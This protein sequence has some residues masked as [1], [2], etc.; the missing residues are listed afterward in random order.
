MT[1]AVQVAYVA[2]VHTPAMPGLWLTSVPEDVAQ[3]KGAYFEH[4]GETPIAGAYHTAS[5]RPTMIEGRFTI[6]FF[7][8]SSETVEGFA[9]KLKS[10][11]VPSILAF[12]DDQTCTLKRTTYVFRDTKKKDKNGNPVYQASQSYYCQIGKPL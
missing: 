5:T 2:I 12:S 8:T 1:Q 9:T 10:T 3:L 7:H 4:Q 6:H 11:F